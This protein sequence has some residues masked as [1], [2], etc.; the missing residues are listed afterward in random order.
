MTNFLPYRWFSQFPVSK[1]H[2]LEFC[3]VCYYSCSK[4]VC[5]WFRDFN[6]L[7]TIWKLNWKKYNISSTIFK[8]LVSFQ[9][10]GTEK[11]GGNYRLASWVL[12]LINNYSQWCR[13]FRTK[14]ASPSGAFRV[15]HERRWE[16][17][18]VHNFFFR[19]LC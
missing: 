12:E 3:K 17:N 5:V 16:L 15:S 6:L 7:A 9:A 11:N 18:L 10:L 14:F 4:I 13:N 8:Q 2:Y 1:S 19:I